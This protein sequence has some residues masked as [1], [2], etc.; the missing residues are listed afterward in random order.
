M[1]TTNVEPEQPD[2]TIDE[3]STVP[4][5]LGEALL[6]RWLREGK[7][8][9]I[10]RV[11]TLVEVL[12]RLRKASIRAT[13]ASDW[14]IH[15]S[16]DTDG[17]VIS[18][19]GYL[20]DIGADRAGPVWGIEISAPVIEREDHPDKTFSYHLIADGWS[21]VTGQRRENLEGSRW[22][23]DPFFSRSKGADEKVDPTD[24]RKSAYSNLHGG[25]VRR[26]GGLGGVPIDAL[27]ECGIDLE[28]VVHV[29]YVKGA[30]GGESA[31]A[32]LGAS[33]GGPA[34]G[35][36]LNFGRS[37]GKR[38]SEL[39]DKDLAWY[40]KAVGDSVADPAKA[41]Y[42]DR[43]ESLLGALEA[44]PQRRAA[45]APTSPPGETP[46]PPVNRAQR[47]TTLFKRLSALKGTTAGAILK[48]LVGK[49]SLT[50]LTDDELATVEAKTDE[51]LKD[52]AMEVLERTE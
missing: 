43:N 25:A 7:D 33:G 8:A 26:L 1:S 45:A 44:E 9:A 50:A 3:P 19:R 15:T 10:Q 41:A 20:Q 46:S 49:D 6:E 18:Q 14:I 48:H 52:A 24:V 31:G 32:T 37:K 5:V 11:D 17:N 4:V 29:G 40:T 34:F 38:V 2:V 51:Q 16:R 28:K 47:Q 30:K 22:S 27:R 35:P 36:Q 23:G 42:K 13:Y 12:E 39:T 21:K